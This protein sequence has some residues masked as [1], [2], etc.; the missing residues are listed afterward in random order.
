MYLGVTL[1]DM[2]SSCRSRVSTN[3][4]LTSK[5]TTLGWGTH[6]AARPHRLVVDPQHRRCDHADRRDAPPDTLRLMRDFC[7][8]MNQHA[9]KPAAN[10]RADSD[11]QKRKDHVR[12]ML[13]RR[14][15]PRNVYVIA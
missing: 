8:V 3:P 6:C 12:S 10:E 1:V 14:R 4:T 5:N 7:E 9:A 15:E 11:G 2:I 13:S